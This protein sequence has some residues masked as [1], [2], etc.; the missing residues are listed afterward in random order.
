[1][2]TG[3]RPLGGR[4][5]SSGQQ[6]EADNAAWGRAC[7][8]YTFCK[9]ELFSRLD[10]GLPHASGWWGITSPKLLL[11]GGEVSRMLRDG[12]WLPAPLSTLECLSTYTS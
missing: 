7:C 6:Q 10:T 4:P 12:N 1:M 9:K 3:S 8:L 5:S 11:P 2:G